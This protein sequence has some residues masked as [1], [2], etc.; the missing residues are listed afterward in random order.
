MQ[1]L[2]FAPKGRLWLGRL[3]PEVV[4]QNSRLGERSE[5]LEPCEV[6][7]R[8]RPIEVDGQPVICTARLV[9]WSEFDGGDAQDAPRWRKSPPIE[10]TA[11]L[12]TP[13]T[14]GTIASAARDVF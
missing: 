10:V 2:P 9:V 7:V 6:G 12:P 14:V 1:L 5:R 4:V 13:T 11:E 3:A 8:L